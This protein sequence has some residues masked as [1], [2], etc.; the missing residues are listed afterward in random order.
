[1]TYAS[2]AV[3][4]AYRLSTTTSAIFRTSIGRA[5]LGRSAFLISLMAT[6]CGRSLLVASILGI[7]SYLVH[8]CAVFGF[9]R[10]SCIY[11]LA[12]I[13]ISAESHPSGV[14]ATCC[15]Y[16]FCGRRLSLA[17]RCPTP[18]VMQLA[19]QRSCVLEGQRLD[20]TVEVIGKAPAY[21]LSICGDYEQSY[22]RWNH[23]HRFPLNYI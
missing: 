7:S 20:I 22:R 9:R 4:S 8:Y 17:F 5:V 14:V 11:R 2:S 21:S 3:V 6:T 1:M 10:V 13:L 12:S 18:T 19:Q 15:R 16:A 23:R